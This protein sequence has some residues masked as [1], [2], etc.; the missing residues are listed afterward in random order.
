MKKITLPLLLSPLLAGCTDF[1][2]RETG[3]Q[4]PALVFVDGQISESAD[5]IAQ[6]QRR[7]APPRPASAPVVGVQKSAPAAVPAGNSVPLPSPS[8]A[9]T[10]TPAATAS[11]AQPLTPG[12]QPALPALSVTGTPGT[13]AV[14]SLSPARNLT[15]EQWVRRIMP[16]G[17]KLEYENALRT[18]LNTRIVSVYTNDQW[19]RVLN[20]LLAEQ[21]LHGDLNWTT[22]TVTLRRPGQQA[23]ARV[24]PAD[25][26]ATPAAPRNPFSSV[27]ATVPAAAATEKTDS[28]P[29][30]T[31]V[32]TSQRQ[33]Q[34]ASVTPS[35]P[36]RPAAPVLTG[37]PVPVSDTG[38]KVWRAQPG[39]TLRRTLMQWAGETRCE[40]ADGTKWTVIWPASVTDYRLD[41]PLTFHGSF[42]SMLTQVFDLYHTASKPLYAKASRMQCLVSVTDTPDEP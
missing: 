33:A 39:T 28:H 40:T 6:T 26:P 30:A 42:E 10:E 36:S 24:Q 11:S 14:L 19:T 12:S 5:I 23:A 16:S 1:M 7:L 38:G 15:L 34:A 37:T 13:V 22:Q 35:V 2:A 9:K 25:K 21:S 18:A 4:M 17:W 3:A 20:R 41:A 27:S 29:A 31:P 8:L 32:S